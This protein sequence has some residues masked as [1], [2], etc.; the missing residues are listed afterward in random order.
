MTIYKVGE[1]EFA[2]KSEMYDFL[3]ANKSDLV[4]LKKA[5]I[6][7]TDAV[8]L[9]V[10]PTEA[11]KVITTTER[12]TENE[13]YRSIVGNTYYVL[14][15]HGDVHVKGCFTRSISQRGANKIAH[16]HD[17]EFKLTAKVGA[18]ESIDEVEISWRELGVDKDGTTT[19]LIA[20]SRIQRELNSKIFSMYKSGSID[21][22]SVGMYYVRLDLALD[23]EDDTEHYKNWVEL[24]DRIANREDAER[25]GYFWVVR[26]AKLIEISAVIAGSNPVTPTLPVKTETKQED[27]S[28]DTLNKQTSNSNYYSL[29]HNY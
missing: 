10:E 21:Q 20:D 28:K 27:P 9:G 29:I 13:I 14:D 17:H 25:C 19:A 23:D 12:D 5:E 7:H 6:K 3:R 24:I 2:T 1:N 11:T 22:H 16:L 15:S 4:S 18:F 8:T 26:E